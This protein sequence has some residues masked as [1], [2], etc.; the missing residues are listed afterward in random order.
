MERFINI[1]KPLCIVA[2]TVVML[3][4]V[5]L[6]DEIDTDSDVSVE[7]TG[8][9][10][11]TAED[12]D[13]TD[14]SSEDSDSQIALDSDDSDAGGDSVSESSS[15]S[16]TET[17]GACIYDSQIWQ[18]GD[19]FPATDGCN[20]CSCTASRRVVCTKKAC[21]VSCKQGEGLFEPGCGGSDYMPKIEEGCFLP[22]EGASCQEGICQ[23]TTINPCV[24]APGAL[25][26][27]A[28]GKSQWLCL[29][30]PA[31]CGIVQNQFN[32]ESAG[33]TFGMCQGDCQYTFTTEDT[34]DGECTTATLQVCGWGV[35]GCTRTNRGQF[36]S[37][38]HAM[39][40]G[41]AAELAGQKLNS[42]YGCPDCAD[43]GASQLTLTLRGTSIDITYEYSNPP[44]I[45][46]EIDNFTAS[47]ISA[48]NSCSSN[49]II[50][51]DSANCTA[52][53]L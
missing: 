44:E 14:D 38:G 8:A 26:C 12:T 39:R 15:D 45:L 21:P 52:K 3:S 20:T 40:Q 51:V 30:A 23:Q 17:D 42:I 41:L 2:T 1:V 46:E 49:E 31:N 35:E 5:P 33:K 22:C 48:L 19:S 6:E 9:D 7:D 37:L 47:V 34:V 11:N 18:V 53:Q 27:D 29:K 13:I 43:G 25:C 24:C 32:I 10:G 50:K 36:T 4:C 16:Q 28:C